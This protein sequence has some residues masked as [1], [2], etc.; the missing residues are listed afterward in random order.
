LTP[1]ES[2][3]APVTRAFFAIL[4]EGVHRFECTINQYAGDGIMAP[5]GA[6]ITHEDHAQT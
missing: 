6:P 1:D 5:F 3:A 4:T 2:V